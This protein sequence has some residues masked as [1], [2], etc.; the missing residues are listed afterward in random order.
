MKRFIT[1]KELKGYIHTF[2]TL[3]GKHWRTK[4]TIT[5][6]TEIQAISPIPIEPVPL[7]SKRKRK[8]R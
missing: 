5:N 2:E 8:A 3:F 1:K 6:N 4:K 7:K